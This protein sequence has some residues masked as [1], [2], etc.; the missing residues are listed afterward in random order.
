M[1]IQDQENGFPLNVMELKP[2]NKLLKAGRGYELEK[3]K[4]NPLPRVDKTRKFYLLHGDDEVSLENAKD[5]IISTHLSRDER[6]EN[7]REIV[8][9]GSPPN[10]KKV[11]DDVLSELSTVSFLPDVVRVVTLYTVNDFFDA[12]KAPARGRGKK[13]TE[14]AAPERSPSDYLA[15]FLKESLPTLPAVL[16]VIVLE[17]YEKWKKINTS[18]PVVAFAQSK[19]AIYHF[20]DDSPQFLFF[21]ALFARQTERALQ[22]WRE[23]LRRIPGSPKP[24][25]QLASQVR[26][27]L[28][29]KTA[30]SPQ[31]QARGLT[32]DRFAKELMPAEAD[33][34][35]FAL[36]PAFRQEKLMRAAANF[37]FTEL[38]S[39]Y[40]KLM[41]LQKY[42][43]PVA[44][45]RYVPDR[46]LLGELW[47]LEFASPQQQSY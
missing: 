24:Y 25:M 30:Q 10:L 46:A 11:L 47:I 26:L 4:Q 3:M 38:L 32:R 36:K 23:W 6:S 42:A 40:E 29:A 31:L 8:P 33:K 34:N 44:T 12:G 2:F 43:I 22:L 7:Y 45:D 41:P 37:S 19:S 39:G 20:K 21:D 9:S 13:K 17:D 1:K 27:L 18:N 15:G 14:T 28:E 35:V 5:Q 16:I